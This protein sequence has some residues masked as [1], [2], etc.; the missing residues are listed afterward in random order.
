MGTPAGPGG[1][2]DHA[3]PPEWH[4]PVLVTGAGRAAGI[5]VVRALAGRRRVVAADSD[6]AAAGL[7]LADAAGVL[8]RG[9]HPDHPR[10]LAELAGR[11]GATALVCTVPEEI[12][13]LVGE[14]D[15]LAAAGLR[16]WLPSP[17]AVAN[18]IDK[19]AFARICAVAGIPTPRTALGADW[20][21]C[22]D[23]VPGPWIIKPRHGRGSR[24]V[25]RADSVAETVSALRR[26]PEPIVQHRMGGPEFTVDALVDRSGRPA[27]VVARWRLETAGGISTRGRTFTSATLGCAVAHLLGALGLDGPANVQGFRTAPEGYAFT[28]VNPCFAAGLELSLAAGA[29]FVG[30]YLRGIAGLPLRPQRLVGRPGVS[31]VRELAEVFGR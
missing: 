21:E 19:W 30:E 9:G 14:A 31:M 8:P 10:L 3:G 24:H 22:P 7:R 2:Q 6:P 11:T 25:H 26:V 16:S 15:R 4:G 17:R 13:G 23:R 1:A 12:P 20:L 28:D 5:A 27:G 29:D 18:C